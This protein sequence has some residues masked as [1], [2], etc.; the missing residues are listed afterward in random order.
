MF[1]TIIL[2]INKQFSFFSSGTAIHLSFDSREIPATA[3]NIQQVYCTSQ[4][5]D[6]FYGRLGFNDY[7][8]SPWAP[9]DCNEAVMHRTFRG[10]VKCN[11]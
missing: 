1:N 11:K 4:L 2:C 8:L 5:G 9:G 6:C 7:R 3:N 10:G